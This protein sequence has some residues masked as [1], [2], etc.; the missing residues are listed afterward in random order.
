MEAVKRV[1]IQIVT[2]NHARYLPDLFTSLD[3]QIS[4]EWTVT[5]ID[6]ASTDGSL[7]WLQTARPTCS[8]LRNFR[9]QGF[10][11]GHNQGF[12]LALSRWRS[13]SNEAIGE[14][15]DLD[16]CYCFLV[17]PDTILDPSC[18]SEIVTFMDSHP[19][20]MIA[21]PKLHR[22]IRHRRE[23]GDA[24][25][26]ERTNVFDSAGIVLKKNRT[27]V[28][29]GEGEEDRGQYDSAEVFGISGA[30]MV[31]R[32]SA[33]STLTMGQDAPFDEE[34]FAYKEDVD[35]CWRARLFGLGVSLI[36]KAIVWH[37]RYARASQV[38]GMRGLFLGQRSRSANV[39]MYSRR[40]QIWMEWK[41]D[42]FA[43]RLLH[44]PWRLWRMSMALGAVIV[45][46]SHMKAVLEAFS[47]R[48]RMKEKRKEIQKR[49]KLSPEEMRNWFV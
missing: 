26:I 35:L 16:K 23:E 24:V 31:V 14:Q 46:P 33:I 10:A 37:Y 13:T 1:F 25:D 34:F 36:P 15:R 5:V 39:N 20:V 8:V 44:L 49:R 12:A 45:L 18:I 6:N 4:D 30:A 19:N 43:N 42:D 7:A 28:E 21:G 29:R 11:R 41:N 3:D 38:K 17:N 47:G 32:A 2:W 48:L 22:A 27:C 9:N 40:N